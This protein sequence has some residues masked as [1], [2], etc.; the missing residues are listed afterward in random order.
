MDGGVT[1]KRKSFNIALVALLLCTGVMATGVTGKVATSFSMPGGFGATSSAS[2]APLTIESKTPLAP[3]AP[4][5]TGFTYQGSLKSGGSPASGNFDFVFTLFDASSAGTQISTPVT[6]TNQTV[7]NSLFTVTL[8]F[9]SSAFDGNARFLEI[10]VRAAGVGSYTTLSPRQPITPAPYALYALK[11]APYKGVLTV[12]QSGAQYTTITAALNSITDN[13]ASIRYLIKVGPGTYTETV[14]MKQFVDIEGSGEMTTKITFAGSPS[15]STGTLIGASNAELR[16]LTVENT[17][18]NTN[19]TAIY[20]SGASPSLLHVTATAAGGSRNFGVYNTNSSPNINNATISVSGGSTAL[21]YAVV[22]D[23]SSPTISGSTISSGGNPLASRVGVVNLNGGTVSIDTSKITVPS[24]ALPIDNE[25]GTTTRVGASQLSGRSPY[26]SGATLT[27]SASYDG[28]NRRLGSQCT[29]DVSTVYVATS[30]GDY[31]SIQSALNNVA[32]WCGTP[33][34]SNRCL[35]RVGPGTYNEQVTMLQNVDIEGSGEQTTRITYT[36]APAYTAGT[37]VGANN[38]ELR[39]LAVENTGGDTY[40][41]AIYNG[42]SPSLLHVTA[43]ASGG[44]SYSFGVLNERSSATMSSVTASASG[45]TQCVGVYNYDNSSTVMTG[46]TASASGGIS[47]YGVYNSTSSTTMRSVIASA[48][49]GSTNYGVYNLLSSPTMNNVTATASGGTFSNDYGV[50]ND[51]ASPQIVNSNI[52][53]NG[54]SGSVMYG[55]SNSSGSTVTIDNSKITVD[56]FGYTI[57]NASG[58]TTRVG[59]SQ[60]SGARPPTNLGTLACAASYDG[61]NKKLGADCTHRTKVAYVSLTDG[62]YTSIQAALNDTA[63]WCGA[64]TAT[65]RCV[66]KVGPG[67]YAEQVTMLQYVDIEGSGEQT[68]KITFSS[69]TNTGTLVGA[70][71]AELRSLTVETTG[72]AAFNAA[73][74]NNN[75]SPS[76]LHVTALASGGSSNYGIQ[77]DNSSPAMNNVTIS[78][79]G[80]TGDNIGV[81]NSNSSAIMNNVTVT[82]TGGLNDFG[83]QNSG[84]PVMNNVTVTASGGSSAAYGVT[85]GAGSPVMNN[86][87][88][89][90]SEAHFNEA[91]VN[92]SSSLTMNNV[93]ASATGGTGSYAVFNSSGSARI[94]RSR[95]AA[96]GATSNYGLYNTATGGAYSVFI[97]S[98]I[99]SGSTNTIS[100]DSEFIVRVGASKLEGGSVST[101]GG[102]V[103]CAGVHDE[104]Y[105]FFNSNCPP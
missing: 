89:A 27:C 17:G 74:Y 85:N 56:I 80:G 3:L 71:N 75:A 86:V 13:S 99:V 16:F 97:D 41:V 94:E 5:G 69:A 12:A 70:S 76:I 55:V 31:T 24:D 28:N 23:N 36:G 21:T 66:V 32:N 60:L 101:G 59:A 91:V 10:A 48:S 50:S 9:G 7:T 38:A 104:N 58:A 64:A 98:S 63:T 4:T 73:I 78:V 77:N 2:A 84:S 15:T 26:N 61:N 79:F 72:G 88:V 34:A 42:T 11:T 46:V 81:R 29:P 39:S 82:V 47:S 18:G 68:T 1:V 8:D 45:G 103:T 25:A 49:G 14:T 20:N 65:N 40:A 52:S 57:N 100:S 105:S 51:N 87:T 54:G 53:A 102:A 95:L 93:T 19:A 44:T 22:N 92:V 37:V 33:S 83:I 96:S 67:T 35:V 62:D 30:G 6:L 43:S 90:A